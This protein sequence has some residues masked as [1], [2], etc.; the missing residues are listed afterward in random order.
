MPWISITF[1]YHAMLSNG[2][3]REELEN[4]IKIYTLS[5]TLQRLDAVKYKHEQAM[6]II[7]AVS[8]LLANA[9][10]QYISYK[11][12]SPYY[13]SEEGEEYYLLVNSRGLQVVEKRG[14]YKRE[15]DYYPYGHDNYI[16]ARLIQFITDF[17]QHLDE[18]IIE[19][20]VN[21][22]KYTYYP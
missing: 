9:V 1:K 4:K 13:T 5:G 16:L 20:N 17:N 2:M 15:L 12:K 19:Y 8:K 7:Y 14:G 6:Q 10:P 11:D 21:I 3:N 22:E 18:L